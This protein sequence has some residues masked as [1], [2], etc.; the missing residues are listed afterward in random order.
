M[1]E[2]LTAGGTV[3]TVVTPEY[4]NTEKVM[5]QNII[6]PIRQ[7]YMEMQK[8]SLVVSFQPVLHNWCNKGCGMC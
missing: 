2:A 6:R 1:E 5:I 7:L 3:D 8:A 4:N